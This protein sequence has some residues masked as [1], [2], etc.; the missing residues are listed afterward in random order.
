[1]FVKSS[2]RRASKY[3]QFYGK[4]DIRF[5]T[6]FLSSALNLISPIANSKILVPEK[7]ILTF[8]RV[9]LS[10]DAS[11]VPGRETSEKKGHRYNERIVYL[12]LTVTLVRIEAPRI[13]TDVDWEMSKIKK[14]K[15]SIILTAFSKKLWSVMAIF[16]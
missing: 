7:S 5:L 10:I 16:C 9:G 11:V 4:L 14:G 8:V 6:L 13:H 12:L 1:M 2:T 15:F 3:Y